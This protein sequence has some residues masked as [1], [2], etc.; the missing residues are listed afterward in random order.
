[1]APTGR[2]PHAA[3]RIGTSVR[4][5][6][7]WYATARASSGPGGRAP[8]TLSLAGRLELTL[9]PGGLGLIV[10][11]WLGDRLDLEAR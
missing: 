8:V 4:I 3:L 7:Q 1:L 5:P 9:A 10:V 11:L 2:N 6:Q